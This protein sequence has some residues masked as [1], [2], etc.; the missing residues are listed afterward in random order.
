MEP[1][2]LDEDDGQHDQRPGEAGVYVRAGRLLCEIHS[3]LPRARH[4]DFGDDAAERTASGDRV[5]EYEDA[6]GAGSRAC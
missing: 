2:G 6:L 3:S 1:A 5:S 4:Y